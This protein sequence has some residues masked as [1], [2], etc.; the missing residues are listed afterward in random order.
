M[1]YYAIPDTHGYF[2]LMYKA[3]QASK[4][5]AELDGV[6]YKIIT[7]GDYIDRGPR[8]RH[9]ITFLMN[10][11][12][13]IALMGNHEDML[14]Q[15]KIKGL[16]PDWWIGN[17][18][19]A[20]LESYGH[21]KLKVARYGQDVNLN[22]IPDEHYTWLTTL[23]LWY[24]TEKQLFVHAG[25][26]T[27]DPLEEISSQELLWMRYDESDEG[28]WKGKFV[29]HGHEI[30]EDGPLWKKNRIGLD[31]GSFVNGKLCVGVFDDS[32]PGPIDFIDIKTELT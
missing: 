17:G 11:P 23:P 10:S 27:N 3:V 13:I 29:V 2:E 30:H 4:A 12:D 18:G 19:G 16:S 32:R 28:G 25:V 31:V 6:E 21:R 7:L 5:D 9:I 8:S 22:V 26:T 24:E 14:L 1:R 15:T 20:T